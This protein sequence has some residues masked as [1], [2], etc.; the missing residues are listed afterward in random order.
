MV[1]P[2]GFLSYF[3][4]WEKKIGSFIEFKAAPG[5]PACSPGEEPAGEA[6]RG[7][8]FGV[9]DNIAVKGYSLSCGSRLLE[10]LTS[11]YTATAVKKLEAAG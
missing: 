5:E 8:P 4:E 2:E 6:L 1:L 10:G 3:E 11:P 7:L 9:K